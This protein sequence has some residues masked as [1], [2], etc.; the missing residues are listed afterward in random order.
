MSVGRQSHVQRG[1]LIGFGVGG[2]A[3]L[4]AGIACA[5]SHD[6]VLGGCKGGDVAMITALAG[7]IG[8]ALGAVAG[9]GS[10]DRLAPVNTPREQV[11]LAP[12]G[13]GLAV[14]ITF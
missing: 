11:T 7:M 2:A 14:S 3:G 4:A 5:N 12:H 13:A 10:T 8:G 1:F 6:I 9:S